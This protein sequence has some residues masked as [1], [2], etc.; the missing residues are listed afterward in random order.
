MY[1]YI[2]IYIYTHMCEQYIHTGET[3]SKRTVQ[4]SAGAGSAGV[5]TAD[6]AETRKALVGSE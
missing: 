1:I 2:Y 6:G 5:P 4:K 3:R